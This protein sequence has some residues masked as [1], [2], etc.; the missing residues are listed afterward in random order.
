M[1]PGNANN[2]FTF[3]EKKK[4]NA[5]ACATRLDQANTNIENSLHE[6]LVCH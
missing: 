6:T 3:E 5:N 2:M 1:A 4:K